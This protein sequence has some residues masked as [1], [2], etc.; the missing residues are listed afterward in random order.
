MGLVRCLARRR[1]H[2]LRKPAA[3]GFRC[4]ARPVRRRQR[5]FRVRSRLP[6]LDVVDETAH[7]TLLATRLAAVLRAV[8]RGAES[9]PAHRA[10]R[11]EHR[12]AAV[13]REAIAAAV[14][15]ALVHLLG[16]HPGRRGHVSVVVRVDSFRDRG[17]HAG[18]LPGVRLRPARLLVPSCESA[19]PAR[20]QRARYLG[21]ARDVRRVPRDV[22][23]RAATAAPW[24]SSSSGPICCRW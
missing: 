2:L 9:L 19:R 12:R 14:G 24:R 13:H 5:F 8:A 15:G 22:A 3:Q 23:A 11:R 20:V 7:A 10:L 4:G 16:L 18:A 21:A 1:G 6:L 17:R